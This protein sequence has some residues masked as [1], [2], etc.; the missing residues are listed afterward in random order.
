M[1]KSV[2]PE[3]EPAG[4]CPHKHTGVK[5]DVSGFVSRAN[6][7]RQARELWSRSNKVWNKA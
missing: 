3:G 5:A 4:P 6:C 1:L 7:V 2:N